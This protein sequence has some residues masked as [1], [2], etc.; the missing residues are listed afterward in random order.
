MEKGGGGRALLGLSLEALSAY[1]CVLESGGGGRAGRPRPRRHGRTRC[2]RRWRRSRACLRFGGMWASVRIARPSRGT[3]PGSLSLSLRVT[4]RERRYR[5]SESDERA[6][7]P[8]GGLSFFLPLFLYLT[9]SLRT[10]FEM[11]A[12]PPLRRPRRPRGVDLQGLPPA[13]RGSRRSRTMRPP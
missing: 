7:R 8:L 10:R 2:R 12:G 1:P 3:V 11:V 5:S 9:L 13:G 6:A 4:R